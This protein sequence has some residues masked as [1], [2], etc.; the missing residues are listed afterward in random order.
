M[1]SSLCLGYDTATTQHCPSTGMH[2]WLC[3]GSDTL[4]RTRYLLNFDIVSNCHLQVF[5]C[6]VVSD[7]LQSPMDCSPP[8]SSVHAILQA[9]RLEWIAISFSN[10]SSPFPSE[11]SLH[12]ILNILV[13]TNLRDENGIASFWF[14]FISLSDI[15]YCIF[16]WIV[17]FLILSSFV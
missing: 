13:F 17:T 4:F 16:S 10:Y 3:L 14:G 9:R 11:G 1:V 2:S 15:N 5:R 8:G 12:S 7:S 6:S